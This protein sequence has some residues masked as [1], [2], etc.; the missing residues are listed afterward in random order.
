[1]ED[2]IGGGNRLSIAPLCAQHFREDQAP[3]CVE[4]VVQPPIG[5]TLSKLSW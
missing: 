4:S 1:M 5:K 3:Q 2:V